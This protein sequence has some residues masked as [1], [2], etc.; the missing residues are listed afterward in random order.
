MA[1]AFQATATACGKVTTL[2]IY[3]DASSTATQLV[4]GL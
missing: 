2:N 1:E 3:L 4:A